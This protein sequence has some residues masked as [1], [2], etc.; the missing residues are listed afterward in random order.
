MNCT[1]ADSWEGYSLGA[2]SAKA[3]SSEVLCCAAHMQMLA[4]LAVCKQLDI[5]IV[6]S[7]L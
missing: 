5:R 4:A 2:A 3:A 1:Y 6:T 7:H